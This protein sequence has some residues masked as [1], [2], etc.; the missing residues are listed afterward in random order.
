MSSFKRYLIEFI[1]IITLIIWYFVYTSQGKSNFYTLISYAASNKVGVDVDIQFL[2]LS[3]YPHVVVEALVDEVYKIHLDGY[4]SKIWSERKF[5]LNYTVNSKYLKNKDIKIKSK[6]K[7]RGTIKGKHHYMKVTGSGMLLDGQV[8]YSL[9]KKKKVFHDVHLELE[10]INSSKLVKLLDQKVVFRGLAHANLYFEHIDKNS[11]KGKI[12]YKLRDKNFH[13][14]MLDLNTTIDVENKK[15]L[16]S[17]DFLMPKLDIHLKDGIYERDKKYAHAKY[18]LDIK[19]L[20][21]FK[22]ELGR[23]YLGSFYARGEIE[24]DKYNKIKGLSKSLDGLLS[25]DYTKNLLQVELIDIPLKSIFQ[26]MRDNTI[27]FESNATGKILYDIKKREMDIKI[28]L[29]NTRVLSSKLTKSI[30]QTF[31]YNLVNEKFPK[32]YLNA[33]LKNGKLYSQITFSNTRHHLVLNNTKIDIDK[34]I[35]DTTILLQ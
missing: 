22:K 26:R 27:F 9:V 7:L 32:S 17:M 24:Y 5:D 13:G 28:V 16:F 35:I 23:T 14:H 4:L 6:V 1:V 20:S 33:Q 8:K 12:I 2:D 21:E 19:N 29:H 34:K 10:D 3:D 15:Y 11:K 25:F 18:E 30:Y 31:N